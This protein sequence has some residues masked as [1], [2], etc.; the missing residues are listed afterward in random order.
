MEE[1]GSLD[2]IYDVSQ[3][4]FNVVRLNGYHYIEYCIW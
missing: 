3:A 2:K 4:F 1:A